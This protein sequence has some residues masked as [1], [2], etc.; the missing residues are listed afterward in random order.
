MLVNALTAI[1]RLPM[2][3]G[4]LAA[5]ALC[6]GA[7]AEQAGDA[8][9]ESATPAAGAPAARDA[10]PASESR[11]ARAV[12]SDTLPYGEVG[13]Y[14]VHGH[15]VF[16][17]DMVEPLPAVVLIH[18]WWGLDDSVKAEADRLAAQGYVV[19]AVDLFAG[20]TTTDVKTARGYMLEALNEQSLAAEN[21]RQAI[22]F[23]KQTAGAPAVAVM[24]W[25]LG[26]G[27][28][29]NSAMQFADDVDATVIFYGRVSD[30]PDRIAK[31]SGPVLGFFG[32]ADTTVPV[33]D[34]K[35]FESEL[36]ALGK[37]HDLVIYPNAKHGFAN[38]RG[39]NYNAPLAERAW[40]RALLF[41]DEAFYSGES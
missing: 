10:A 15:F 28:A 41:L 37:D 3:A 32:G 23:V 21:I 20:R 17:S 2:L 19:L 9:P 16:P 4:L 24:G 12:V 11:E 5:T 40:E 38:P 29:L 14:L 34:I 36:G 35:A 25:G 1:R 27:L 31:L 7:C 30:D 39:R 22:D 13:S 6:L 8:P 33:D 26:G 18:E